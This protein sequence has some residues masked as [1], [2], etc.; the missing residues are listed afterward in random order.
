MN[1]FKVSLS[2]TIN[3]TVVVEFLMLLDRPS[4]FPQTAN[5][6]MG[7]TIEIQVFPMQS[8]EWDSSYN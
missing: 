4:Y 6:T 2:T 7:S 8:R 3:R 1:T 5:T